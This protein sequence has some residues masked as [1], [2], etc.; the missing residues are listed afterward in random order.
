L[1]ERLI[2]R[3]RRKEGHRL[4]ADDLDEVVNGHPHLLIVGTG[5]YGMMKVPEQTEA[6]LKEHGIEMVA[7]KTKDACELLND[8]QAEGGVAAAFHLTC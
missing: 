5:M 4:L 3:W 2:D 6:F 1:T 7:M 8:K